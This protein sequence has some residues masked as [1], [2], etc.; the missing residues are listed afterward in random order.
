MDTGWTICRHYKNTKWTKDEQKTTNQL[1]Q[2]YTT[3]QTDGQTESRYVPEGN[4]TG[5]GHSQTLNGFYTNVKNIHTT[6][7]KPNRL[8]MDTIW[9][10][11]DGLQTDTGLMPNRH[12]TDTR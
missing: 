6:G 10:N 4:Y 2:C 8:F 1:T 12:K 9:H 5:T 3:Y 7:L 11:Q